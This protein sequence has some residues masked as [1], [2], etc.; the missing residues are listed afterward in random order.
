MLSKSIRT[1]NDFHWGFKTGFSYGKT[2]T[3]STFV[4]EEKEK[5]HLLSLPRP[6]RIQTK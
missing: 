4:G 5:M 6:L 2:H 3:F 1:V